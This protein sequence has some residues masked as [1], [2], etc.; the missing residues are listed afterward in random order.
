MLGVNINSRL[1][2]NNIIGRGVVAKYF[3]R[4]ARIYRT[5]WAI[6]ILNFTCGWT[7]AVP[8]LYISTIYSFFFCGTRAV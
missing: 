1:N 2:N 7:H 8:L 4:G 3:N 5:P 6:H